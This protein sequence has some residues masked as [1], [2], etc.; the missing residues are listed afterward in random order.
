MGLTPLLRV[1]LQAKIPHIFVRLPRML[2]E[3]K[4][5]KKMGL[6][7]QQVT[8]LVVGSALELRYLR[9]KVSHCRASQDWIYDAKRY[10]IR[11]NFWYSCKSPERL[12]NGKGLLGN[13]RNPEKAL[14][15]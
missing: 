8:E 5:I 15:L 2:S 4:I 10:Q 11:D 9:T 7:G 6:K 13:Q 14:I 3:F 12:N 1:S